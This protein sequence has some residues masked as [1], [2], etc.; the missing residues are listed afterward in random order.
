MFR[1]GFVEDG[2]SDLPRFDRPKHFLN[3]LEASHVRTGVVEVKLQFQSFD[4]NMRNVTEIE[5]HSTESPSR[6]QSAMNIT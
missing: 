6:G 2:A 1:P 5:D 3:G 4:G